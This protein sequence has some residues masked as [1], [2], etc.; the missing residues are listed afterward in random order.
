MGARCAKPT[1][2]ATGSTL[3]ARCTTDD[4]KTL[5]G[6]G[7]KMLTACIE[8]AGFGGGF[9][10]QPAREGA[11]HRSPVAPYDRRASDGT[12]NTDGRVVP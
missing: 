4:A 6:L 12:E 11:S 2:G 5:H 8:R 7:Q 10:H 3:S 1:S 9:G